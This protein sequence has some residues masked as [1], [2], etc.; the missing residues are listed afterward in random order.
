MKKIFDFN[1]KL[2]VIEELLDKKPSFEEKIIQQRKIYD[3]YLEND[4]SFCE[5]KLERYYEKAVE[6]FESIEFSDEDL[7]KVE[8]L[9]FDGGLEIYELLL[10]DWDGED[11]VFDIHSIQGI[12]YLSNLKSV[13]HISIIDDDLIADIEK[14]GIEVN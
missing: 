2:A 9:T 8:S 12:E 3:M 5:E 14:M 7:E 4:D 1:F 11:D 10:P 6:L 13:E